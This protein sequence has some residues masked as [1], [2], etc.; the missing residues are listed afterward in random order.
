[1]ADPVTNALRRKLAAAE[2]AGDFDRIDRIRA[3]MGAPAAPQEAAPDAPAEPEG[4]DAVAFASPAARAAARDAGM[5]ADAFKWQHKSSEAGFTKADVERI[6]ASA[7]DGD[8]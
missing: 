4:L 3:R 1:M 7:D 2:A 6:A 5:S 8:E